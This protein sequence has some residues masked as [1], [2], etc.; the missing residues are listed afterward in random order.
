[1]IATIKAEWRKNRFRPAFLV[2][3]G[4]LAALTVFAYGANWYLALHPNVGQRDGGVN[5]LTLFPDQFVNN[6]MG[7]GFPIGAA[8]AIVLGAIYAGSEYS[9]GTLKTLLTQRSG[10]VTTWIGRVVVF[11]IWMAIL[12]LVLFA[13]GAASSVVVA[14]F[15]G[16]AIAWP[17]LVDLA[18]GAAAIWLIFS[19]NGALGMGLGTLFK[20]SAAALGVGLVYLFALQVIFVRFVDSINNGAYK[21][22]GDLFDGQNTNALLH[23][24]TSAAFGPHTALSIA[25][26]RAV[27]VLAVYLAAFLVIAAGLLRQ[28]DVT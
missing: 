26:E 22:I 24:F 9:W 20:N 18:K 17:A 13:V 2:T 16:H 5:I 14:S 12:T 28:R 1:M 23:T 15:Q 21:W 10:R 4:L 19:V 6:V 25:P 11:E 8:M 7:A 3:S 27:T